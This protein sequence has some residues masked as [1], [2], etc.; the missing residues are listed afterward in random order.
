MKGVARMLYLNHSKTSQGKVTITDGDT[1]GLLA[2][3]AFDLEVLKA[4]VPDYALLLEMWGEPG[5]EDTLKQL[6]ELK[7]ERCWVL[8]TGQLVEHPAAEAIWTLL[9][10]GDRW[11]I[12][13]IGGEPEWLEEGI[14]YQHEGWSLQL[15]RVLMEEAPGVVE[16][17][18]ENLPAALVVRGEDVILQRDGA[19]VILSGNPAAILAQL[20]RQWDRHQGQ[21]IDKDKIARQVWSE[22]WDK[23]IKE[24]RAKKRRR[25]KL[26]YSTAM[27]EF[28][29]LI[30]QSW[31]SDLTRLRK[32]L[33]KHRVDSS[34]I[35]TRARYGQCRL[36][37][38]PEV[39]I[40]V[41]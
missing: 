13:A 4:W 30:G 21:W 28:W 32:L 40:R 35:L 9:A 5:P 7:A 14:V 24:R 38:P 2:K 11:T 31:S 18:A 36:A 15:V 26:Q 6:G 29:K 41:E 34:L 20:C 22:R 23:L 19:E 1:V 25:E 39:T 37:L 10:A 16:T 17:V 8:P 33:E 12:R 27:Q 3:R